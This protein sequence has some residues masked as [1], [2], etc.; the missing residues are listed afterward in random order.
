[1]PW[2]HPGPNP[3]R[4]GRS[5]RLRGVP[6]AQPPPGVNTEP[7]ETSKAR[8]EVSEGRGGGKSRALGRRA[9]PAPPH[10]GG[11]PSLAHPAAATTPSGTCYPSSH[12]L[13]ILRVAEF[14]D[15]D[16]QKVAGDIGD[17]HVGAG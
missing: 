9:P 1:M 6:T 4:D 15:S 7:S 2:P 3:F 10:L 5:P 17:D 12:L 14:L 13:E 11:A 8:A 16:C